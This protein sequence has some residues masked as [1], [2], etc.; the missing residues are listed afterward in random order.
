MGKDRGTFPGCAGSELRVN[1]TRDTLIHTLDNSIDTFA[2]IR[3][4]DAVSTAAFDTLK[5][6]RAMIAR[7]L[8]E[9][10]R[11]AAHQRGIPEPV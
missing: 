1:D 7:A 10:H 9:E 4:S 2:R 5:Q 8:E 11:P 6:A 3:T